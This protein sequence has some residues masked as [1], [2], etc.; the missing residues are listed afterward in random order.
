MEETNVEAG[1]ISGSTC[2]SAAS[3]S[4]TTENG[5]L[6]LKQIIGYRLAVPV[7]IDLAIR[8]D[9]VTEIFQLSR[10]LKVI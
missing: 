9:S 1:K 4:Y 3:A 8:I 5:R 2:S 7:I 10:K 6:G